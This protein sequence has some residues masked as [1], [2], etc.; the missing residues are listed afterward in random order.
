V[1]AVHRSTSSAEEDA[2]LPLAVTKLS[3]VAGVN[4]FVPGSDIEPHA[5]VTILFGENGTGKTATPEY[6]RHWLEVAR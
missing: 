1:G 6:S 2:E 3:E 4:A 5:S